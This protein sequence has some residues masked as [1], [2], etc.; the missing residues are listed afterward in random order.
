LDITSSKI[1]F[2]QKRQESALV[3]LHRKATGG[4]CMPERGGCFSAREN[5]LLS[6]LPPQDYER[7]LLTLEHVT[8]PLGDV[9]YELSEPIRFGYFPTTAVVSLLYTTEEGAIA[10]MGLVGN[11]GLVGVALLLGGNATSHRAA[12]QIG[13]EAFRVSASALKLEFRRGGPVQHLLLHYTQ[14]LI[15]QISQTA[16]CNRVH[17]VEKRLARWLLLCHDRAKSDELLMTQEYVANMLGGRRESVT[18]AAG[19]LQDAGLIRY[20]RGRI[21][22]VDR[23]GLEARACECYAIVRNE[24]NRLFAEASKSDSAQLA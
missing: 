2:N 7:L 11:D 8:L 17:R 13:G 19:H 24:C 23:K 21:W 18:V 9:L 6:I 16:V 5:N 22:V 3:F 15:T 10:D 20:A 1:S 12:V 14:A 4:L